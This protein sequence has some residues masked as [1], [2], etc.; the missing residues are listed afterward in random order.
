MDVPDPVDAGVPDPVEENVPDPVQD[1]QGRLE[2]MRAGV[3]DGVAAGDA[4]SGASDAI[5]SLSDGRGLGYGV[6][7]AL[8]I[9]PTFGWLPI[10]VAISDGEREGAIMATLS[11]DEAAAVSERGD[12]PAHYA[13]EQLRQ[14]EFE[15]GESGFDQLAV[16]HPIQL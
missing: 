16:S 2:A 4:E 6:I 7:A 11:Q 3:W 9:D 5:G 15:S 10:W 1:A 13:L 14:L 8:P 12:E